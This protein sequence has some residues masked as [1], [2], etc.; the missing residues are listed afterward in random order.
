MSS[1]VHPY[2]PLPGPQQPRTYYQILDISPDEQDPRVIEE[3]AL[4]CSGHARAYQL[5]RES[6]SVQRLN[7]IAQALITLLD[8]VR[9]RDYDRRL[10]EQTPVRAVP[11]HRPAPQRP[12]A[13]GEGILELLIG[14]GGGCDVK[15][16]YRDC[17]P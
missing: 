17:A 4:G 2:S 9:R 13:P 8:P 16:V 3:A 7:G 11:E 10:G 12:A 6:E 14:E 1:L 5:T 15:L